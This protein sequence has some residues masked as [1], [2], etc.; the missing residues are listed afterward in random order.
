MGA[1]LKMMSDDQPAVDW[2]SSL[3]SHVYTKVV[4]LSPELEQGP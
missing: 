3:G 2:Y 4:R 1:C